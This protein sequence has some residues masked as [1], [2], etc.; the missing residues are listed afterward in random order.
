[1][2]LHYLPTQY[3]KFITLFTLSNAVLAEFKRSLFRMKQNRT[4]VIQFAESVTTA[5]IITKWLRRPNR[6]IVDQTQ[7]PAFSVNGKTVCREA[8]NKS[9]SQENNSIEHSLFETLTVTS[10]SAVGVTAHPIL[11][12]FDSVHNFILF[13]CDNFNTIF[14]TTSGFS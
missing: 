2:Q 5:C 10:L 9:T 3:T 1:M 12:H 11:N 4:T 13:L 8:H 14:T 6:P 7:H